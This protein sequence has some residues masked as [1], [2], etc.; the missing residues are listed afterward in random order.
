VFDTIASIFCERFFPYECC[1]SFTADLL[2]AG[3]FAAEQEKVLCGSGLAGA[4]TGF[5]DGAVG[6]AIS[7][8]IGPGKPVGYSPTASQS[9][10]QF[11]VS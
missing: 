11:W 9:L 7:W 3:A 4:V 5:S 2:G 6:W 8:L 1:S 10:A